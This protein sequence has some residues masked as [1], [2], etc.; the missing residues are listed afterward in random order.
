MDKALGA[1]GEER[2]ADALALGRAR[3]EIKPGRAT[4]L[5]ERALAIKAAKKAKA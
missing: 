4:L 3:Q 2:L 5:R 1:D